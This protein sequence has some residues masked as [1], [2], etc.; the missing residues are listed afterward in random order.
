[1]RK[2][3]IYST[4][5]MLRRPAKLA[6]L[7]EMQQFL[8]AGFTAFRHMRGADYFLETVATREAALIERVL[9][10]VADPFGIIESWTR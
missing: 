6:G 10:G 2:P 4:L 8:E 5:K 9:S 1:V 3:L 7:A